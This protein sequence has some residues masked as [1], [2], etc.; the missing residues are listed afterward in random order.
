MQDNLGNF[1]KIFLSISPQGYLLTTVILS[2]HRV[3]SFPSVTV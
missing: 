3:L 2:K 1:P